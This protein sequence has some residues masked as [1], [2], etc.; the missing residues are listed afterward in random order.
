MSL[1]TLIFFL[2][3]G[4]LFLSIG[5]MFVAFAFVKQQLF[6]LFPDAYTGDAVA[7]LQLLLIQY[8]AIILAFT[9]LIIGISFF[10]LS[11]YIVR[12][13]RDMVAAIA[14]FSERSERIV[15]DNFAN[16]PAEIKQLALV[17][18]D[19][20][21]K[22]DE[23]HARDV[24]VSRVKS[25]F[26]ST[27]A[28]QFRTPLTGIRWALE[29]LEKEQ[30]T[31]SQIA[32]VS[33]AKDKSHQL[34]NIVGTLLD[35]SAIESGKNKYTFAPTDLDELAHEI[36]QEFAE[37]AARTEV[38]LYYVPSEDPLPLAKAD[39]VRV[40]WILNNIIENAIRYTP[41]GG[42]VRISVAG[43]QDRVY[44]H[45]RDTGIGIKAE[46]RGN[47]FERFYR[48]DNAVAKENAGNGLGLYIARTIATDHGGD[49]NFSPNTDGPGTTFSL[50]LPLA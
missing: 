9:T 45:V 26:I 32:L 15:L 47:I 1:R 37:L 14:A 20:T 40:K 10:V 7:A 33:S 21:I 13:L 31:E 49:L 8:S 39:R 4:A 18:N 38:S 41:K 25:D 44:V 22:V 6:V 36:A 5:S 43:S 28:H 19:F 12:P 46:D 34:V 27:A 16:A 24:E 50:S 48:A 23:A 11:R 29:A 30:L 35:I 3:L 42:S 17:F 2:I